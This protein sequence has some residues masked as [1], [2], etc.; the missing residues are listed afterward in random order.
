MTEFKIRKLNA[1][2]LTVALNL[3]ERGMSALDQDMFQRLAKAGSLTGP[4]AAI[5]KQRVGIEAFQ[6]LLSTVPDAVMDWCASLSNMTRQEFDE[7][8]I[9]APLQVLEQM[10][11]DEGLS[12]FLLGLQR[13]STNGF[14]KLSTVLAAATAGPTK[15]STG[16]KSHVSSAS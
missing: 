13:V 7:L 1:G 10:L 12:R 11:E 2:D 16:S 15:P 14:G 4:E 5:E 8:P 3:V 6:R 9:D